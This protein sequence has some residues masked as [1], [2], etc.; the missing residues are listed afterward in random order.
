MGRRTWVVYAG[1]AT[2]ARTTNP[3]AADAVRAAGVGM[4]ALLRRELVD[5]EGG[6][7]SEVREG[8]GGIFFGIALLC[9]LEC[10]SS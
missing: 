5:G 3:E 8:L 10:K 2:T 9:E 4:L 6:L 1:K 7:S